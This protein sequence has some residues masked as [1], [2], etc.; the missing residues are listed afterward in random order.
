MGKNKRK[1]GLL[2]SATNKAPFLRKVLINLNYLIFHFDER[3]YIVNKNSASNNVYYVIRPQSENVGLMASYFFV[4]RKTQEAI[5][6]GYIPIVDFQ[7]F[8]CQYNVEVAING[9]TNAWEYYFKQPAGLGVEVLNAESKIIYSGWSWFKEEKSLVLDEKIEANEELKRLAMERLSLNDIIKDQVRKK[10]SELL[11][12]KITLG[13]FIRGTDYVALRPKGHNIQPT[14][15][16][17][18]DKI[19]E[20]LN[21]YDINQIYIVTEDFDYFQRIT[22]EIDCPVV[23]SDNDFVKDYNETDYVSAS[24]N[25]DGFTR[26]MNYLTRLLLLT[27]CQYIVSSYAAGSIYSKMIREENPRD[28]YWFD[29]GKY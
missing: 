27:K 21:N 5:N 2:V 22:E 20:F 9:T 13:V 4:L 1:I 3:E 26:G 8:K 29:L 18:I 16:A 23:M 7:N 6:K 11:S 12:G 15:E 28:E 19:K 14:I 24:I 25:T 17:F 10:Y